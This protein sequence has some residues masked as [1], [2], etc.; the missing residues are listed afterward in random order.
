MVLPNDQP[1]PGIHENVSDEIYFA[2]PAVNNS[3]LSYAARSLAHYR[4]RPPS[5]ATVSQLYGSM[6]HC[7]LLQPEKLAERYEVIPDLINK[8]TGKEFGK[9]TDAYLNY[10]M[11][12]KEKYQRDVVTKSDFATMHRMAQALWANDFAREHICGHGKSE[13]AVVWIDY[14]SGVLCKAKCDRWNGNGVISDLKTTID[15]SDFERSIAKYSYHRQAAMYSDGMR[16]ATGKEH[17]FAIVAVEK[18]EPFG[19]RGAFVSRDAIA[20]GR[21]EY[22]RL[23]LG[24]AEARIT[25][26]WPGYDNPE[27]W[28]LP[29]WAV[30]SG[31][32]DVEITFG[33]EVLTL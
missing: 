12:N 22:K 32:D 13:V 18:E 25:D 27:E 19:C 33:G 14:E 29:G 7:G 6:V 1:K 9:N 15:A 16:A 17:A 10:I 3:S 23:L 26:V 30:D 2:W 20:Q 21:R 28:T 11:E 24:I 8:R 4:F 31:D 5:P